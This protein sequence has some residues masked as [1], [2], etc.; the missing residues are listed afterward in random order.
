MYQPLLRLD[1]GWNRWRGEERGQTAHT[2]PFDIV[3]SFIFPFFY[4]NQQQQKIPFFANISL[5]LIFFH[6][7]YYAR[8]AIVI[9]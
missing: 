1:E 9:G 6:V 7:L 2:I 3:N 8:T 5:Y 4:D